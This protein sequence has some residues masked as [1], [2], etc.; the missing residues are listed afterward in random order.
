MNQYE[1]LYLKKYYSSI[2]DF[3]VENWIALHDNSD[4]SKLSR[5]GK[6][7][8]RVNKAYERI[9]GSFIDEFG[10]GKEFLELQQKKIEIELMKC[11]QLY[12]NDLSTQIFIDLLQ[13]EIDLMSN[14]KTESGKIR[15]MVPWVEFEMGG[16]KIDTLTTS[17]FEFYN[18][19]NFIIEK[20]KK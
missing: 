3:P 18:R 16:M 13:D 17:T 6:I 15:K 14:K 8:S 11:K 5:T 4:P 9:E 20:H 1:S 2:K 19:V 12:S 7:C 10:A